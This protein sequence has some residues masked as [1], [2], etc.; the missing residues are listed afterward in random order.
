[1]DLLDSSGKT[2]VAGVDKQ[3]PEDAP[4]QPGG[5]EGDRG[6]ED[7]GIDFENLDTETLASMSRQTTSIERSVNILLIFAWN[8]VIT[9]A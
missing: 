2:V 9:R 5:G 1:M 3:E 8:T 7:D 4:E 6:P